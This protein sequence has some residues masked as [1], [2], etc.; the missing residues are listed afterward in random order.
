MS[1]L[2]SH[3]LPG[4]AS[5]SALTFFASPKKVSKEKRAG[6]VDP[7]RGHAALLEIDGKRRNSPCG[8]KHLRLFSR[9]FL[10]DSPPHNGGGQ[11]N[12]PNSVAV[13]RREAGLSSA[14]VGGSGRALFERSEFSPT[15][16]TASSARNRAAAL[17]SARLLFGDFLLAR[18]EKVTAPSGA[19]PTRIYL[20]CSSISLMSA[21]MRDA[22]LQ[23][24]PSHLQQI[25]SRL[26]PVLLI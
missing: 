25:S 15:P 18:Q 2:A 17:S 22:S 12:S 20:P 6:F 4:C 14:A 7:L 5:G 9:R 23:H 19:F 26:L 13:Q 16:H 21:T 1:W 3:A 11:S 8:L 24:H 10:R